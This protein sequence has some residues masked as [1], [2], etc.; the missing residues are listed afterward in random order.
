VGGAEPVGGFGGGEPVGGFGAD[1]PP[2]SC[3]PDCNVD[4][5][6]DAVC[7]PACNVPEC[8]FDFGD[9]GEEPVPP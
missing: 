4:A 8:D 2:E 6:G 1:V 5:L 7:N 3:A 9:C